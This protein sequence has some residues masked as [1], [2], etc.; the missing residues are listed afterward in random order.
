MVESSLNNNYND[1]NK[2]DKRY[3]GIFVSD[4]LIFFSCL[5]AVAGAYGEAPAVCS[6]VPA[7]TDCHLVT[8]PISCE[9][10]RDMLCPQN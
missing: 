2:S 4:L 8:P 6:W 7:R 9:T 5:A 10:P 1:D 3:I